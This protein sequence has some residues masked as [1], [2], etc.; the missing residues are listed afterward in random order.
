MLYSNNMKKVLMISYFFPPLGGSGVQRAQKFVKYLPQ[1]NWK[2]YVLTV[3]PVEYIAYD[4]NLYEEIKFTPIYRTESLDPMRILHL[5]EKVRNRPEK[6]YHTTKPEIKKLSRNI[7]PIDSKIGWLP[8]AIPAGIKLC[9]NRQIDVIYATLSPYSSSIAA[10]YISKYT[11][12]PYILDYRDLWQGKPDMEYLTEIHKKISVYWERKVLKYAKKV[13]INTEYS[14]QKI[15]KIY[16]ETDEKKFAVIYNGFDE[17]DFKMKVSSHKKDK[18]IFTYTGGFYG[19]RTPKF[20]VEALLKIKDRLPKNVEF[21][22]VG[23]YHSEIIKILQK[24]P[25]FIK[26]IPQVTHKE[27]I[28][29]LLE[30]DFL[31]LF[32]AKQN[33]EIVIPAKLFEYIAAK[34]PILA[35]LPEKGEAAKIIKDYKLGLLCDTQDVLS[36]SKNILSMIKNKPKITESAD[37]KIFT[38]KFQTEQL[39]NIMDSL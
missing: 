37:L 20:F 22:F 11:G 23:N 19:E 10:Y 25:E 33:S 13:I 18:L 14:L 1:F 39:S 7:F 36:I 35:M 6:I 16:P 32:I 30:S 5:I 31:M 15:K 28:R 38:R 3:K 12:L 24:V 27:S 17:D 29:Y 2:P 26:I 9:K 21:K 4:K 8:F 34:K